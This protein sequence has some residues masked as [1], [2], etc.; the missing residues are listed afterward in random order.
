M[1]EMPI[2][3]MI[4]IQKVSGNKKQVFVIEVHK[5]WS[6]FQLLWTSRGVDVAQCG[7]LVSLFQMTEMPI[8][9]IIAVQKLPR[10]N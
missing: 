10:K 4:T 5:I 2:E 8:E 3:T 7:Y 9:T 1:T 6:I